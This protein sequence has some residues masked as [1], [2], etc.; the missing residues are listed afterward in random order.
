M[1]L[2]PCVLDVT[3][4]DGILRR[5]EPAECTDKGGAEK[6]AWA[7]GELLQGLHRSKEIWAQ[8]RWTTCPRLTTARTGFRPTS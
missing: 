8:S 5:G 4:G 6:Q 1:A 3:L 2:E 7:R